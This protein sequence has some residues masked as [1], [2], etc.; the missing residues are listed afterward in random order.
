MKNE[1]RYVNINDHRGWLLHD[2]HRE[3]V[4]AGRPNW[5]GDM[6]GWDREVRDFDAWLDNL[7]A[8]RIDLL[9]VARHNRD[10]PW[11]IERRWA[12]RAPATVPAGLRGGA[13]GPPVPRLP[14]RAIPG[15][16]RSRR[17]H[18]P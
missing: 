15:V 3:A 11:P 8:E 9:V 1:V 4:A 18:A 14:A 10:E 7:D 13:G 12:D 5:P 16:L 2:Y 17:R 6:P